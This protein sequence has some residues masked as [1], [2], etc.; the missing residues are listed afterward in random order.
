MNLFR[1][2]GEYEKES[3]DVQNQGSNAEL[4]I[5]YKRIQENRFI[6]VFLVFSMAIVFGLLLVIS[7][8]AQ[9]GPLDLSS[10]GS[11]P[12]EGGFNQAPRL[13]SLTS[14]RISPQEAGA[15]IVWTARVLDRTEIQFSTS[16]G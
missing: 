11:I 12:D 7:A 9:P 16:S 13:I 10:L 6:D 1:E 4:K 15:T 8:S 14:D 3:E 5:I 2:S